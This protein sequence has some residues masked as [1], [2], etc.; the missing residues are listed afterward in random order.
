MRLKQPLRLRVQLIWVLLI[1]V[2]ASPA[3]LARA[4]GLENARPRV[5]QVGLAQLDGVLSLA[6]GSLTLAEFTPPPPAIFA[7]FERYGSFTSATLALAEPTSRLELTYHPTLGPGAAVRVDVRGSLDGRQWMP[8]SVD[9]APATVVGF[10]RPVRF[11][12]YRVTLMGSAVVAPL[13]RNLDLLSSSQ[14]PT[15]MA[16]Q[17]PDP[18]A[19]APTFRVRATRI[20]MV[21]GRTANGWTI[22]ARA[23]FV[24]LPSWTVLSSRGG[25]EYQV[26][27]SY[28]GRSVVVP[29]YDVGP[30]SERDDYW[31]AKRDGYPQLDRGWPMDHAAYY[32]GFN[33][34]RADKGY[35]S[36]PTAV[37]VGDGA[38]LNDLGIDGDQA[39]LEVT[40]LWLGQDPAAGPPTRD[41]NA[42]EHLVDE[43][44]GDFWHNPV[45]IGPSAMGCGASR[46]AYWAQTTTKV[47][48]ESIARWQPN[49][50]SEAAYDLFVYVP[51]C[52]ARKAPTTQARYLI[53]HRD[54][55]IEVLV[56]QKTQTGWVHL[57]RF[58]FAAGTSGFV[59]LGAIADDGG[60]LWYDQVRWVVGT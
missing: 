51:V 26:R 53:Q 2:L 31:D 34:G 6:D 37:D 10:N 59:Q 49:L 4:E 35:V 36:Y 32:D 45:P 27:L 60:V 38:W 5:A 20:G 57:G 8:W 46:H 1:L 28:H 42:R 21:G 14:A 52:P 23:R 33:G 19:I 40:Y 3:M 44:E 29:V 13:V 39:E 15:V 54:G 12:Q 9:L 43:L 48:N 17:A 47:G 18:Y 30:Y 16:A 55:A 56:N 41:P 7:K 50:P 25:N 11:A 58:P 24:A 22:P